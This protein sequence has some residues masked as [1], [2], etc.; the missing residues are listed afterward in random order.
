MPSSDAQY[1][2]RFQLEA[3]FRS[4][5]KI[6]LQHVRFQLCIIFLSIRFVRGK[7]N[8]NKPCKNNFLRI[9]AHLEFVKRQTKLFVVAPEFSFTI[10]FSP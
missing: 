7:M 5:R 10:R 4:G 3:A 2:M 8:K 9:T 6:L 1:I